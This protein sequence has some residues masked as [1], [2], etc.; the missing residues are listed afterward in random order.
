M[1]PFTTRRHAKL[2]RLSDGDE[3]LTFYGHKRVLEVPVFAALQLATTAFLEDGACFT[4]AL[5]AR[6]RGGGGGRCAV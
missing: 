1:A 4:P 5:D 3:L 6:V 2:W